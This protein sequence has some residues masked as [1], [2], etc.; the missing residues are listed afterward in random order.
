MGFGIGWDQAERPIVTY[1]KYDGSGDSQYFNARLE[2]GTWRIYQTSRWSDGYTWPLD[3]TGSLP[4]SV[5]ADPVTV[6]PEGRLLQTAYRE[7]IGD[8]TWILNASDLSIAEELDEHP[9]P[10]IA[11]LM[12]VRSGFPNMTVHLKRYGDWYLRW[13]T[14]PVNQ[15]QA[16]PE[17]WPEPSPVTV[18]RLGR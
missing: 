10:A 8:K 12:R 11:E 4:S 2:D 9:V 7:G 6:D 17:P 3:L 14:L 13:E 16:Y 5:R 15:D 18:Y 1:H